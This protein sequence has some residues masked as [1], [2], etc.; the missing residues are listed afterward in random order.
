MIIH[1]FYRYVYLYLERDYEKA[2]DITSSLVEHFPG[3]PFFMYLHAEVLVKLERYSDY[4]SIQSNLQKFISD[5]P[6]NQRQEC[7][8]KF[9][10]IESLRHFQLGSYELAISSASDVI[11]GYDNE[12]KWILGYAHF[13]RGKSL[14]V[15][16]KREQA[17]SDYQK[18]ENLLDRYPEQLEAQALISHPFSVE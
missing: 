18:A 9:L 17:V 6:L 12:F 5:G 7:Q 2:V 3:H 4:Q 14:D 11:D 13:I 1:Q 8:D 15:L 16:G 10:Y